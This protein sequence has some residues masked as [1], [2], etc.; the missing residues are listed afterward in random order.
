MNGKVVSTSSPVIGGW[1]REKDWDSLSV[2][3]IYKT[4]FLC[5]SRIIFCWSKK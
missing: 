3:P 2:R 4:L 1:L 5:R